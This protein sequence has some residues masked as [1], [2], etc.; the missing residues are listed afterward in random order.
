MGFVFCKK[1]ENGGCFFV[2][3]WKMREC[4][5]VKKVENGGVFCCKIVENWGLVK[6]GSFLNAGCIMYTI[7]IFLFYILLMPIGGM[8]THPTHPVCLRA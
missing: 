6:S 1:L 8:R 7:T 4:V 3:K 2:K 5:F